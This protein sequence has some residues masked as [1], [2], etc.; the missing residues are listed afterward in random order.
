[1][2]KRETNENR[3]A[4]PSLQSRLNDRKRTSNS[5]FVAEMIT[6]PDVRATASNVRTVH[7]PLVR[8]PEC[9]RKRTKQRGKKL[10]RRPTNR[11][12]DRPTGRAK[13]LS[14][15]V[16]FGRFSWM[17]DGFL[18]R[19]CIVKAR[20]VIFHGNEIVILTAT[21]PSPSGTHAGFAGH[22]IF[23]AKRNENKIS[24]AFTPRRRSVP[25]ARRPPPL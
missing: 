2:K 17:D 6:L 1:M 24:R 18:L 21:H 19:S 8:Q 13:K 5:H 25:P 12:T 9:C 4:P 14:E 15:C 16:R 11:P 7:G 22:F 20:S 23:T 10:K 3:N